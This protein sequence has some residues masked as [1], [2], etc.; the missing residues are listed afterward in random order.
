MQTDHSHHNSPEGAG[1]SMQALRLIRAGEVAVFEEPRPE[2][3]AGELLVRVTAVGLCGSDAHWYCEGSIGD[4][5]LK[6]PLVLGHEIGGVV[7]SGPRK[8]ERVGLDPAVACLKCELCYA[9]LPHLC[10]N[11]RFAGHGATDGALRTFMA[12]PEHCIVTV[13]DNV[14]DAAAPL[15][16]P[17]GVA[18]HAVDLAHLKPGQSAGVYGCGPIG[19]MLITLLRACGVDA[20]YAT[21]LLDHRVE[22]ARRMGAALAMKPAAGSEERQTIMAATGGRGVDVAFDVSGADDAIDTAIATVK[23]AGTVVL[24][25]IPNNDRSSFNAGMARRKETTIQ[26]CRRMMPS[27]LGRAARFAERGLIDLDALITERFPLAEGKAAFDALASRRGIKVV[28]E[29]NA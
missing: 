23:P 19:L 26:L 28:V 13:P 9:G 10:R 4:A 21:D 25:G 7:E 12:W 6:K 16:E 15:L 1:E 11:L 18:M 22:A 27:D 2:P 17:L 29:P 5:V 3:Q 8:G 24:V 20:V 14:S